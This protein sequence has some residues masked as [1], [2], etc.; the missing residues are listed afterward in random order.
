M[1]LDLGS[2]V[3]RQY[4]IPTSYFTLSVIVDEDSWLKIM[5]A[6]FCTYKPTQTH[7]FNNRSGINGSQSDKMINVVSTSK[8]LCYT[9]KCV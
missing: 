6:M 7:Y 2:S 9:C 1:F 4:C 8:F 5:I 3:S